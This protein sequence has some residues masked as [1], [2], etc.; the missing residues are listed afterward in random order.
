MDQYRPQSGIAETDPV[1]FAALKVLVLNAS[2]Y[3]GSLSPSE[4]GS[5][6]SFANNVGA[7]S[8]S[9]IDSWLNRDRVALWVA[10]SIN[11]VP[12]GAVKNRRAILHR[13]CDLAA[14]VPGKSKSLGPGPS[15]PALTHEEID[16]LVTA[17]SENPGA[18]NALVAAIGAGLIPGIYP[19]VITVEADAV[20]AEFG[21]IRRR[22]APWVADLTAGPTTVT[23]HRWDQIR[24]IAI[25]GGLDPSNL[26]R[27]ALR[28]W[29]LGW[30]DRTPTGLWMRTELW[31]E[32]AVEGVLHQLA[33]VEVARFASVLRNG[34]SLQVGSERFDMR[35]P[36]C[37]GP[38]SVNLE[39]PR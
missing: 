4:I 13:F 21:A 5:L 27:R 39:K 16:V 34:D 7:T 9:P 15:L 22:V 10:E 29:R 12:H 33:P 1:L 19:V 18:R 35:H 26:G 38:Q 30:F 32:R 11:R 14:D 24:Q 31:S 17:T 28:A 2:E 37:Q 8:A 6:F 25:Q 20:W 3:F 23:R 36:S